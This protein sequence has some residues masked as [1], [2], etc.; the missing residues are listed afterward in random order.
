MKTRLNQYSTDE[1]SAQP[2][3][4]WWK[5]GSASTVLMKTRLNQYSTD[6]NSTQPVQYWWKLDSTNTSRFQSVPQVKTYFLNFTVQ[7]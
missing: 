2:V 3:Q 1:N 6:E 5:L 7:L 4:Y